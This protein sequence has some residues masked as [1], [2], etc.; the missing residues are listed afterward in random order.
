MLPK[1]K[2][3]EKTWL[4]QRTEQNRIG[5]GRGRNFSTCREKK[6][7]RNVVDV[8][9]LKVNFVRVG[10]NDDVSFCDTGQSVPMIYMYVLIYLGSLL[11]VS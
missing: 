9:F 6:R 1:K 8:L 3:E 7:I 2:M 11:V 4:G 10:V 5:Y